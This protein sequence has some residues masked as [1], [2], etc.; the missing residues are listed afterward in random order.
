MQGIICKLHECLGEEP[1]VGVWPD[2][3]FSQATFAA[4]NKLLDAAGRKSPEGLESFHSARKIAAENAAARASLT[5]KPRRNLR[6]VPTP[7]EDGDEDNDDAQP[8]L[9]EPEAAPP[10]VA[11]PD[12]AHPVAGSSEF[13]AAEA[14]TGLDQP[15]RTQSP[16]TRDSSSVSPLLVGFAV[17]IGLF[18]LSIALFVL[19]Q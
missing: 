9:F 15:R 3:A 1:S 4:A 12:V 2:C 17:T 11:K 5:H 10:V 16:R 7:A 14:S 8:G 6:L 13:V 19:R 18:V